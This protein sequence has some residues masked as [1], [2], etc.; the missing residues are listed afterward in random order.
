MNGYERRGAAPG[1]VD[2]ARQGVRLADEGACVPWATTAAIERAT[3]DAADRRA[4][5]ALGRRGRVGLIVGRVRDRARRY[6]NRR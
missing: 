2:A 5:T 3:A 6:L 4:A 1:R